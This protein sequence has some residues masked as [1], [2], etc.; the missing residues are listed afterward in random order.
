MFV[1]CFD[2]S[3]VMKEHWRCMLSAYMITQNPRSS[4]LRIDQSGQRSLEGHL[5][6]ETIYSYNGDAAALP[7]YLYGKYL[8]WWI[9][10]DTRSGED[11]AYFFSSDICR[12]ACW[13]SPFSVRRST[14]TVGFPR[15]SKISLATML[16]IDILRDRKR[17][18]GCDITT[19][20]C[21]T[22]IV[23]CG[24]QLNCFCQLRFELKQLERE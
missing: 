2:L 22:C 21:N 11:Y 20:S 13:Q 19:L 23:K 10:A 8:T 15:E 5:M 18:R 1:I 6:S 9:W 17:K 3:G 24:W 4:L 12:Q 16:T 7:S 14:S